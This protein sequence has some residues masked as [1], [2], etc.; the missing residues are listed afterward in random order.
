V[1]INQHSNLPTLELTIKQISVNFH[2]LTVVLAKDFLKAVFPLCE[3]SDF[4][5]I[6]IGKNQ[7]NSG[8]LLPTHRTI[9]SIASS[10]CTPK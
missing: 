6:A 1:W 2:N 9:V 8:V 4:G 5:L 7:R 10:C 3:V